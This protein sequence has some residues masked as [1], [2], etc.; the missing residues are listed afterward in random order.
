MLRR[1]RFLLAGLLC[2]CALWLQAAD[3]AVVYAEQSIAEGERRFAKS[4]AAHVQRWYRQAG[5]DADLIP[6]RAL[7]GRSVYRFA[8]LVDCYTPPASV[9]EAVRRRMSSGTKFAVCYSGSDSLARLFG[10]SVGTYVRDTEGRWSNMAFGDRRPQ[11]APAHVLQTSTNLYTVR[12][13]STGTVPM[14]YWQDRTGAATDVAWW[15]TAGGHYWM[16]HILTADGD[17]GAKQ[18]LLLAL[19]APS[20]PGVWSA[21]AKHRYEA[22]ARPLTDGSLIGRIRLLPKHSPRRI[23]M[24]R[25]LTQVREQQ[26][27]AGT[28]LHANTFSAYRAVCDLESMT[29]RLYGMTYWSRPGE[30]VAVWDHSGRG[31]Y[32]GNWEKTAAMLAAHGITDL[33]VN[34]AG[35]AFARYPSKILPVK[36]TENCIATALAACRRHNIRFHAWVLG[37]SC[38]LADAA[39]MAKFR[40]NGWLLQEADGREAPWLDPTHPG[41][42]NYLLSIIREL[43]AYRPD[44]IHLDFIRYPSLRQS[45]GPRIRERFRAHGGKTVGWPDCITE[46][47]GASRRSFLRWRAARITDTVQSIRRTLRAQS[48]SIRLS[49]AVFGKYPA[50]IDSVGQ[51]WLSWLRIGLIDTAAPMNYTEDLERLRD[52]LGTQTADPRIAPRIICGIGVT[53][54]ESRLSAVDVLRQTEIARNAKC[55]GIALFDLDEFLRLTILPVLSEGI[56]K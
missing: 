25:L 39:T 50:C 54:S 4:L 55:G 43:A 14:A 35:A 7:A 9:V 41:V 38:S 12:S 15:K 29:A 26:Q 19:A 52:W 28:L 6:D 31:L 48:P 45:L 46:A 36:T 17:E 16:T 33:Y 8:V 13:V 56:T 37:F 32:P 23:Q 51:D 1:L 49:A 53:A 18:Q 24:E 20:V 47:D 42:R 21:A 5:I 30:T 3:I 2:V 40:S 44:G 34:V 10:L 11:G 22:A 27:R